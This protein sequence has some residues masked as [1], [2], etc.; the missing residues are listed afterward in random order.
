MNFDE[1]LGAVQTSNTANFVTESE[2]MSQEMMHIS[3]MSSASS[4]GT[5]YDQSQYSQIS[6]IKSNINLEVF[7][8]SLK[9]YRLQFILAV[10]TVFA[11]CVALLVVNINAENT[12]INDL[13]IIRT[14]KLI[15]TKFT[16][17]NLSAVLAYGFAN[18]PEF[19]QQRKQY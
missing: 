17:T 14:Q 13:Q 12:F 3:S 18:V 15:R 1:T 10:L 2:N 7:P 16:N 19:I 6:E 8:Q 4:S 11:T 9:K 5:S